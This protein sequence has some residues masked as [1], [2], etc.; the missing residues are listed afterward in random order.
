MAVRISRCAEYELLKREWCPLQQCVRQ[1]RLTSLN[2]GEHK[3]HDS[4]MHNVNNRSAARALA[5]K[6]T[7]HND[8]A[9]TTGLQLKC[10]QTH[11]QTTA[12]R[13]PHVHDLWQRR[14]HHRPHQT[15][16]HL[17]QRQ[18]CK[19][20]RELPCPMQELQLQSRS[21][22]RQCQDQWSPR[23]PTRPRPPTA[24]TI[25]GFDTHGTPRLFQF[26]ILPKWGKGFPD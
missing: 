21:T 11:T 8:Q 1:P 6:P 26:C 16:R 20:P 25:F 19:H 12:R 22:I 23:K 3:P 9:F 18:R 15:S 10:L 17:P 5:R 14:K 13:Q 7:T 4:N 24:F 2:C